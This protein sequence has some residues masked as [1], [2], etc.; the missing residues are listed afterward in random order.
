[1][2]KLYGKIFKHIA[3]FVY[4]SYTCVT[5]L[6]NYLFYETYTK[7]NIQTDKTIVAHNA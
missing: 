6:T 3:P 1:M 2:N 4:K 5:V 7:I